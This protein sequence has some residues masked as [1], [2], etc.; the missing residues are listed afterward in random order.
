MRMR[1]CPRRRRRVGTITLSKG[2]VHFKPAPGVQLKEMDLKTDITPEYDR[3]TLG[4]VK[5]FVIERE[6]RFGGARERQR[7]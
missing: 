6:D 1:R 5:F 3:L 7:Q 2:K 4:R